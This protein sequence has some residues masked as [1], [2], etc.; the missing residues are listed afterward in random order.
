MYLCSYIQTCSHSLVTLLVVMGL[1]L[2]FP[3][4]IMAGVRVGVGSWAM[5][6]AVLA[7]ASLPAAAVVLV[8]ALARAGSTS[9]G[10]CI[11]V[12][13]EYQFESP[14]KVECE[15]GCDGEAGSFKVVQ[16]AVKSK[17]VPKK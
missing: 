5:G 9:D 15:S 16:G 13:K 12:A 14:R 1:T 10:P 4:V 8:L 2:P 7:D 11:N 3:V 17:R 6:A